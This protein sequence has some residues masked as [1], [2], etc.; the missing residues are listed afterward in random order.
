M[1]TAVRII[2]VVVG[3]VVF[4]SVMANGAFA[5]T[6]ENTIDNVNV[7]MGLVFVKIAASAGMPTCATTLRYVSDLSAP[8]GKAI[9]AAALAAK[10][11][12]KMLKIIGAGT[13][14]LAPG[15][16]ED[17]AFAVVQ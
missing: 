13:C 12:G 7:G 3:F 8:T 17:A 2:G 5:S 10:L 14:N 11:S 9:Y 1:K 6:N 15:D 16:S 4:M